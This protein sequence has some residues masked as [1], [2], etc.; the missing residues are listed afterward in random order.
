MNTILKKRYLVVSILE[1][2]E[3]T[4]IVVTKEDALK[5]LKKFKRLAKQDHLVSQLTSEPEFWSQQAE[6]RRKTYT[7]L[8]E[9]IIE[10]GVDYAYRY[11]LADYANLP[12]AF[13]GD[14]GKPDIIGN[15]QALEMFFTILGVEYSGKRQ[16]YN[17]GDIAMNAQP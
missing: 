15:R 13:E 3:F 16:Q 11:A 17:A 12:F 10:H 14:R 5:G 7:K 8:M 2:G 4:M 6:G 9:L 1:K